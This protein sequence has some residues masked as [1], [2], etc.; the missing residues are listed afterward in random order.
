ME[1]IRD[2][3]TPSGVAFTVVNYTGKQQRLISELTPENSNAKLNELLLS[4]IR[5]IGSNQKLTADYF[6]TLTSVDRKFML[7][8]GRQ[9]TL[10][11]KESFEFTYTWPVSPGDQTKQTDSHNISFTSE[12]FPVTPPIWMREY[13]SKQKEDGIDY[14][15]DG[16]NKPFPILYDSYEEMLAANKER[17]GTLPEADCQYKW[18]L[19]TGAR[20]LEKSKSEAKININDQFPIHR[21]MYLFG[22]SQDGKEVWRAID[23]EE[24]DMLD[25]EHLRVEFQ[26]V[27]GNIDTM[28]SIKKLNS[29]DVANVD[30]LTVPAFFFPSLGR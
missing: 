27:E 3:V 21:A 12:N 5:R 15:P 6:N 20:E 22:V 25:V 26:N 28:L 23:P 10:K 7:V 8:V 19:I 2:Y 1:R 30:L 13:L 4:S 17:R 16:H 24:T 11:Y 9:H 14:N 18:E 29:R